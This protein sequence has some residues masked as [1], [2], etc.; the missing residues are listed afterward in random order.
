[1]RFKTQ[2]EAFAAWWVGGNS[3]GDVSAKD[4]IE[5]EKKFGRVES[6]HQSDGDDTWY[7][8]IE[9]WDYAKKLWDKRGD[10][11]GSKK[12]FLEDCPWAK[13]LPINAE[14]APPKTMAD[15]QEGSVEGILASWRR[16]G[17]GK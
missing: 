6:N 5:F 14:A 13:A 8:F 16:I 17:G 2:R 1:M 11:G 15:A 4:Q 3:G 12:R 10:K 9:E 7:G